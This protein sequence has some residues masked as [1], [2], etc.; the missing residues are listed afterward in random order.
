VVNN[1]RVLQ[2]NHD[3]SL[4]VLRRE[5]DDIAGVLLEPMQAGSGKI[6]R[7]Y[8]QQ[9]RDLCSELDIPLV[10][11]EVV[12]GFRVDYGGVQTITGINLTLPV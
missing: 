6:E 12:T 7:D 3:Y 10:F 1:T 11:D 8:L 9:L 4:E 2:F 5:A